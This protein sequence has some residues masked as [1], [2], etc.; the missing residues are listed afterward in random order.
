M[1]INTTKSKRKKKPLNNRRKA[2][3]L[4]MK[5]IYRGLINNFDLNQIKKDIKDDP[6]FLL[7]D[8][9]LFLKLLNGVYEDFELLKAEIEVY[10]D[11]GYDELSPIELAILYCSLYELKFS[12]DVPYKVVINEAIEITKSFGGTDGFKF[13]NGILNKAANKHRKTE[14]QL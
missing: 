6:D 9:T 4:A 7:S 8:E 3:E 11:R 12:L 13:V 14:L 1:T 2:R 10:L 5:S